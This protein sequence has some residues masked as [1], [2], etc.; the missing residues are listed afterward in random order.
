MSHESLDVGA[1]EQLPD[2]CYAFTACHRPGERIVIVKRG[3]RG[4]YTTNLDHPQMSA[5]EAKAIV[6]SYNARL[7]V[8]WPV[9]QAML[10]GS[11]FGF[12][13]PGADPDHYP[14]REPERAALTDRACAST[15]TTLLA[16]VR[17]VH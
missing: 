4:F 10:F 17:T 6:D 13:A 2:L 7:G 14:E 12:D 5:Q 8:T 16:P 9:K 15:A 11:M 3:E 1:R